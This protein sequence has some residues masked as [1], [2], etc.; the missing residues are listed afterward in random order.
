MFVFVLVCKDDIQR[1]VFMLTG[2]EKRR[3]SREEGA[4]WLSSEKVGKGGFCTLIMGESVELRW[5]F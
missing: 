3:G 5:Y 1:V 2:G 4:V